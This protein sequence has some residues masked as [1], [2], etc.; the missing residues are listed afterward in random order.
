MT[1]DPDL[2]LS[3]RN[4][5]CILCPALFR[6]IYRFTVIVILVTRFTELG[7]QKVIEGWMMLNTML[8][9]VVAQY[10]SAEQE[11]QEDLTL[12]R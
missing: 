1:A 9:R 12:L 8:E 3:A 5:I 7:M 4:N 6:K 11:V 10:L 2:A